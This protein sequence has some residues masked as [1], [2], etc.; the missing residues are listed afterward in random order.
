LEGMGLRVPR[1]APLCPPVYKLSAPEIGRRSIQPALHS[2]RA[3]SWLPVCRLSPAAAG[4]P[5]RVNRS[6]TLIDFL[7]C[8]CIFLMQAQYDCLLIELAIGA[9]AASNTA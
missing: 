5:I 1:R 3:R 2:H 8:A 4:G 6:K 9:E 7:Y